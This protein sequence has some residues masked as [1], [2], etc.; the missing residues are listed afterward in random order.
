MD[1]KA[2]PKMSPKRFHSRLTSTL[3]FLLEEWNQ[4]QENKGKIGI[5]W[6]IALLKNGKD[7]CPV[8]VSLPTAELV[9]NSL[10]RK[11]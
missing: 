9:F 2:V 10:L 5:E 6:A 11:W 7:W 1:G 8:D 3:L 4:K